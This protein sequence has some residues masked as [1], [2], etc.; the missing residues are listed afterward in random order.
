[1]VAGLQLPVMP[2]LEVVGSAGATLFRQMD[3]MVLKAGVTLGVTVIS[4]VVVVAH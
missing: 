1:M 3:P 4:N 2:L